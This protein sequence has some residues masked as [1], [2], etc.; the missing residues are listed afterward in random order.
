MMGDNEHI[1]ITLS[2]LHYTARAVMRAIEAEAKS[3][4]RH[5]FLSISSKDIPSFP[6]R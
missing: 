1:L 2:E 6:L 5:S 3:M 4:H